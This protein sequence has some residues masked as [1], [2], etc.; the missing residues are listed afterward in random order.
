MGE[1]VG[2][3]I[4]SHV[5]TIM[6]PEEVRLELNEGR[7]FSLVPGLRRLRAEVLDR[8]RADTI[9]V[10]DTHWETTFEHL[11]TAHERRTGHFTSSELP[12]GMHGI[13]YDIPGDPELARTAEK[14][15]AD[16]K[17]TWVTAT[18]DPYLPVYYATVNLWTYLKDGERWVT[19]G[20]CQTAETE[21]FLV[22]G[23][24]LAEAVRRVDRRVVLI[25]S[26]GLSH[27]FWPLRE[28][29]KHEGADPERHVV[30][31]RAREADRQ[32]IEWLR[33]GDH[34]AVIDFMPEYEEFNPEGDFGHYLTMAG[35]IGGRACTAP[36]ELFSD[37][38][39]S[40]GTGQVHIWFER[41]EDGWTA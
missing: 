33:R 41:P 4:V 10:F 16:R 9:L 2:A 28:L 23:E 17:D 19:A 25:A 34:R 1:I 18:D 21:D 6:L 15:A 22:F 35:A 27:T 8:L 20:V 36:G 31:P 13:P 37:Y 5:P 14:V 12:R 39:A 26:G 11:V 30:S 38:E 3:G 32:V 29:R 40:A 24:V 7:D